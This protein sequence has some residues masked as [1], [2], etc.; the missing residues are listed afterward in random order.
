M[1]NISSEMLALGSQAKDA[2]VAMATAT[3]AAKNSFLATLAVNIEKESSL[4]L[5][6]N[7]R[8]VMSAKQQGLDESLIDRLSL[9][10]RLSSLIAD[11]RKVITLDDPVGHRYDQKILPNGLH[12]SKRRVPLGVIALIYEA[13]PNVTVDV[14]ILALKAGNSAILRGGSETLETNIALV[15]VIKRSLADSSLPPNAVQLVTSPERHLVLELLKMDRYIDMVIPRGGA[16]LQSFCRDHSRIP[17]ITGGI[18]ICHLFLDASANLPAAIDVIYNAKVQRP[19]VCNALDTLLI[20]RDIA[21]IALPLV[22]EQLAHGGVTFRLDDAAWKLSNHID[23]SKH[24]RTQHATP[25]DWHVEWLG[26]TLGIKIVDDL[27]GAIDHI[28]CYSSGHSDGILTENKDHA[29]RFI[30][31]VDSSTVYVN[32]STRFTD[33]AQLGLGAEVAISTQKL[34]ARG[35]MGLQELTSY[36]WVIEGEY[37]VRS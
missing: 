25:E 22:I 33:G 24:A 19:T 9:E 5:T 30:Q 3:T 16:A 8:D 28:R 2:A 11:I 12:V 32:A 4:I 35:P 15:E 13:R 27:T 6:A 14:S 21:S 7:G 36:Q 37:H 20:H 18:G 34:H 29:Q 17:V 31:E 26:L 10:G 23:A 1:T